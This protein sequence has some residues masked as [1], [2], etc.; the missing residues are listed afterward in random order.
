M[1]LEQDRQRGA[2]RKG[3]AL[4]P[5]RPSLRLRRILVP[6]D[7]SPHARGAVTVAAALARHLGAELL[8]LHVIP[9]EE[10]RAIARSR[11][12]R[13]GLDAILED[14]GQAVE[15]HARNA[16]GLGQDG[17]P[18]LHALAVSGLPAEGILRAAWRLEADLIVMATHGRTG[19]AHVVMG[20]VA[21]DVLR[22]APCPVLTIRPSSGDAP[23]RRTAPAA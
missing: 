2:G 22:R 14:L 10:V 5:A 21:E 13:R 23:T 9:D 8:V 19:L 12:A 15:E 7:F 11:L 20:S 17:D 18:L 1:L 4:L 3:P 16:A 6:V